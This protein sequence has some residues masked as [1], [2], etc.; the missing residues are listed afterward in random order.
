RRCLDSYC[1]ANRTQLLVQHFFPCTHFCLS[2]FLIFST[3][4]YSF[5]FFLKARR[6]QREASR[7]KPSTAPSDLEF[8]KSLKK[9][10]TKGVVKFFNVMMKLR[11]EYAEEENEG[12]DGDRGRK[13]QRRRESYQNRRRNRSRGIGANSIN[14]QKIMRT[15]LVCKKR[16]SLKDFSSELEVF[17]GVSNKDTHT[18]AFLSFAETFRSLFLSFAFPF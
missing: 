5:S 4:S 6:K 3:P 14:L 11:R 9:I 10:A 15:E 13:R 2:S 17:H 16:R 12:R 18:K 1:F 7:V 8:E